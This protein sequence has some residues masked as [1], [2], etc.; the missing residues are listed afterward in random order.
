MSA[1]ARQRREHIMARIYE[2]GHVSVKDLSR[3]LGISESTMRRD[4]G[5]LAGTGGLELAHGGAWLKRSNDFSFRAKSLRNVEAK[6]IIGRLAAEMIA[7][8]DQIFLDS[9]TTCFEMAPF[10]RRKPGLLVIV[11]STRLAMELNTSGLS[12]ILLG[13]QYRPDRMDTVGPLA[14]ATLDQLRGYLAFVG[15]DGM[16][17]EF[18]LTASDIDSA[19]LYA[20]AIRNARRTVLLADHSKFETPSLFKIVEFDAIS[21]IVT[22]RAPSSEWLEFLTGRGIGVVF[23][24]TTEPQAGADEAG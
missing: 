14:T 10:L 4:L 3:E 20:K 16:S 19:H 24:Q 2:Q 12:L 13:G 1:S 23:P 17:M 7:D 21:E 15:V 6:R 9:G 18:G 5:I 22:D 8:G 11:N